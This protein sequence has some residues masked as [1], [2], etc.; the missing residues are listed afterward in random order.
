MQS[1]TTATMERAPRRALHAARALGLIALLALVFSA[2]ARAHATVQ[3]SASRPADLQVYT[4][5]VPNERD[6][7]SDSVSL[8]VPAQVDFVLVEDKPG[9]RV[10]LDRRGGRVA[11][12]RWTGGSILPDFYE[13]LHFIARNPVREGTLMWKVIQG[14]EDGDDVSWIG[15][16]ESD[17][18]A[19][20]T[21]ISES[22]PATDVVSTHGE[23]TATPAGAGG[24]S[25]AA[26]AG[27][28]DDGRDGLTLALA[29]A[30]LVLA[31]LSLLGW[32]RSTHRRNG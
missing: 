7:A 5:R 27:D 24:G 4:V 28:N 14:Y 3:P 15:P 32:F 29:I 31:A 30:A 1:R 19:S 6:V 26:A 9:W 21:R 12:I 16:P 2:D 8:Q 17:A 25:T 20:R 18:P 13:T 22:A 23:Q 10:K 11:V